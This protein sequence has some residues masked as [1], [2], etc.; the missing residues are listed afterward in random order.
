MNKKIQDLDPVK[1]VLWQNNAKSQYQ[2]FR[3]E[4]DP[5]L[6]HIVELY[7]LLERNL[8]G[9]EPQIHQRF[10]VY[11][12]ADTFKIS[13]TTVL[14]TLRQSCSLKFGYGLMGVEGFSVAAINYTRFF[15][16]Q[17]FSILLKR[18]DVLYNDAFNF[19]DHAINKKV[20]VE[21]RRHV[22]FTIF[23]I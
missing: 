7:W 1:G 16:F 6:K 4:S 5:A 22:F 2:L 21:A 13:N 10:Y 17:H 23:S 15:D 11:D 19:N 20:C 12:G 14:R 8:I 18:H 9:S 3:L